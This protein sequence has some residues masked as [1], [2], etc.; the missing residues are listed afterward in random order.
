MSP[1]LVDLATLAIAAMAACALVAG[2]G[3]VGLPR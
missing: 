1:K 3:S 2:C